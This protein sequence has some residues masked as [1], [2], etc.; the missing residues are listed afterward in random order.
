M[1]RGAWQ[2]TVQRFPWRG[3][4]NPLQYSCLEN[5]M[6]WGAWWATIHRV[7]KNWTRLKQPSM[8]HIAL[9]SPV[10]FPLYFSTNDFWYVCEM[11]QMGRVPNDQGTCGTWYLVP[12]PC[13]PGWMECVKKRMPLFA[14]VFKKVS[15][16]LSPRLVPPWRIY[17]PK[18]L[19]NLLPD[20]HFL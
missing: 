6:D 10:S 12:N 20:S 13:T 16:C 18:F 19:K 1:D 9:N 11:S 7:A 8:K 14:F 2:G 3:H 5:P 4:S 15:N 17:W